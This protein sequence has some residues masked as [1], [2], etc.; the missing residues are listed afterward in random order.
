MPGRTGV[1][2][3]VLA[4]FAAGV[5]ASAIQ[6]GSPLSI[7]T[8]SATTATTPTTTDVTTQ[9][10]TTAATTTAA[11]TTV[12]TTTTTVAA[13]QA[14]LLG[15][16]ALPKPRCLALAGF[17]LLEPGRQALMLGSVATLPRVKNVAD[18]AVAYPADGSIVS[19]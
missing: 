12:A 7:T 11:T 10:T 19:A 2:A 14:K 18:G 1:V 16:A 9:Q 6:A 15:A 4:L 3:L 17:A 13:P 8:T 5:A